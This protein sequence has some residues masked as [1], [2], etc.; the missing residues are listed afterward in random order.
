MNLAFFTLA[1]CSIFI[2]FL[3]IFLRD[4]E[5]EPEGDGVVSPADGKVLSVENRRISIFMNLWDVHVNRSPV[6]GKIR[7]IV[8]KRGSFRPAFSKASERNERNVIVIGSPKGD[9]E[10][11]QI[12]GIFARRILCWVSEGEEVE[13]AQRI[14]MIRFGSRV[15]VKIPEN[16]RIVV[17]KGA[18]VKAGKSII[19]IL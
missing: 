1:G 11:V 19:A 9:F 4:P 5:R 13:R 7:K 15:E 17:E 14:G 3:L 8:Y 18:K 16:F 10:V 2:L 6:K 12:A